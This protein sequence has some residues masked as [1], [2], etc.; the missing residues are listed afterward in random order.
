MPGAAMPKAEESAAYIVEGAIEIAGEAFEARSSSMGRLLVVRAGDA[1]TL[2]ARAPSRVLM[3]GG[4]VIDGPRDILRHVVSS[5]KD[6]IAQAK[7]DWQAGRFGLVPGETEFI[8][9]PG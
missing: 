8:P 1:V 7:A 9:L 5:S 6:R 2:K 3:L 4:A